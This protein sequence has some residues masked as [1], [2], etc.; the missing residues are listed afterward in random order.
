MSLLCYPTDS[1]LNPARKPLPPSSHRCPRLANKV[2]PARSEM[3]YEIN[4]VHLGGDEVD[5]YVPGTNL[6]R[7]RVRAD[8]LTFVERKIPTK[9][10]NPFTTPEP[11]FDIGEVLERIHAVEEDNLKRSD[12]HLDILKAYLET[13]YVPKTVTEALESLTVEQHVIW[14]KTIKKIEN[15]LGK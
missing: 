10:S 4:H 3:V 12:E 1:W 15:L 7:F 14:K 8:S 11:T 13:Q 6:M 9:T 5:L 2:K